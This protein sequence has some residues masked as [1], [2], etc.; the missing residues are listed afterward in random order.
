MSAAGVRRAVLEEVMAAASDTDRLGKLT[1]AQKQCLR[2][3]YRHMSSKDIARELGISPHSVDARL[4]S[5][6]R[7]LGVATRTEAALRLAAHEAGAPYQS[8]AYQSPHVAAAAPSAMLDPDNDTGR[9]TDEERVFYRLPDEE[10]PR[11]R[12]VAEA[13]AAFDR[14]ADPYWGRHGQTVSPLRAWGG[15]ND[16]TIGARIGVVLAIAI[17]SALAFGAILSGLASLARLS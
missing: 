14:T 9:H 3:V 4:R 8:P 5:A 17:A 13:V 2:L 15:R 7:T 16:L 12:R 11:A 10:G 1:E 6:I